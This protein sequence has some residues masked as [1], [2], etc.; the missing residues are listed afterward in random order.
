VHMDAQRKM[1][2]T[3]ADVTAKDLTTRAEIINQAKKTQA[4]TTQNAGA[5]E[6]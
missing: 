1:H 4:E 6:N 5:N 3:H 2:Q